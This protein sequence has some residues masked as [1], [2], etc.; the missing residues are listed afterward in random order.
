[1]SETTPSSRR[2]CRVCG[3]GEFTPVFYLDDLEVV[4]CT[5]C[6]FIQMARAFSLEE[7]AAYYARLREA[8]VSPP[9]AVWTEKRLR[10][11]SRF[12][13]R[14][15]LRH[16]GLTSG[17]ILEVGSAQGH[18]L[19]LLKARGFQ[20]LG[21]EPSV[22]GA[23]RHEEQGIPVINAILEEARLPEAHFDAVC[24][25]QVFEHFEEPRAVA[26]LLF[27]KLKPGGFLMVEVP[28]IFSVGAKFEKHPHKL[29]NR[30]HLNYFSRETMHRLMTQVGFT[31]VAALHYDY[32]GLALP[33]GKSLKK[34]IVPLLRPG[35]K[36]PLDKILRREISIHHHSPLPGAD[37]PPGPGEAGRFRFKALGKAL[38]A[39]L[40]LACG[41]LAIKLHRGASLCWLGRKPA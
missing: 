7:L 21:V 33:F 41:Y 22:K 29:F 31:P 25:F 40:N 24:L 4:Q 30:E 23:R 26:E 10:R 15:L 8:Q 11:A 6:S 18:F 27:A 20:V 39:P 3:G 28:D 14:M 2:P 16:T 36:G 19:A 34:I 9:T 37:R 17:Y 1:M 38:S 5:A 32:D 13:V 12:R 35:L